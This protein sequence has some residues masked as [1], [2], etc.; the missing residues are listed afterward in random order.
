M[1]DF[2]SLVALSLTVAT[3]TPVALAAQGPGPVVQEW[4]VPWP[5]TRPRDPFAAPDGRVWFVGQVGNYLGVLDPRTGAFRRYELD[6][7]TMPHN[8]IVAPDGMVWFAGN[9]N[10]MIGRLDPKDG[11]ITR[12]PMPDPRAGDPHTLV[13]DQHGDLWFT[14][15]AGNAVGRL[16]P[17]TGTIDLVYMPA[18]GS[19]PYGIVVDRANRPWFVEFGTNKVGTID[20]ATLALTEHVL[21]ESSARPRRIVLGQDG[22]LFAGDYS[23]GKL[24]RL[25]P[26]SGRFTQWA[27]PA[28]A[29]S[30][31]YAMA[32]DDKGRVWQAETGPQPNRLVAFDPRRE[33]F[34]PP[35]EISESGGIVIRHM[36]FDPTTR[37]IW[38]GTD[39]GTIGRLSV[40]AW[41]GA[42]TTP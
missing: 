11:R 15:Q 39:A 30:A 3:V 16:R 28:G 26:K 21:P 25:D 10:A 35:V 14:V 27:N 23:G 34:L 24:W 5:D 12:F 17:A 36:T 6:P 37:M 8:C 38:F 1:T 9:R 41:E 32:G 33:A 2:R 20:P 42:G 40:A 22:S 18:S 4:T 7:G 19:R 29:R 31:P 13:F